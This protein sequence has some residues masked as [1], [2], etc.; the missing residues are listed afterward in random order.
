M[1]LRARLNLPNIGLVRRYLKIATVLIALIGGLSAYASTKDTHTASSVLA[2]VPPSETV[3]GTP[4][5]PIK[6]IDQNTAQLALLAANLADDPTVQRAVADVGATME[7]ASALDPSATGSTPGAQVRVVVN[8]PTK[9][10]A[11]DGLS[12]A[13]TRMEQAFGD[14][15]AQAGVSA[16]AKQAHLVPMVQETPTVSNPG[17]IRNAL[18]TF[19]TILLGGI[20]V[21]LLVG[22]PRPAP[23]AGS[24]DDQLGSV[25]PPHA[26]HSHAAQHH[27]SPYVARTRPTRGGRGGLTTARGPVSDFPIIAPDRDAIV[28]DQSNPPAELGL[29]GGTTQLEAA[30]DQAAAADKSTNHRTAAFDAAS[31]VPTPDEVDDH[32]AWQQPAPHEPGDTTATT[33]PTDDTASS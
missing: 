11:L 32:A 28:V 22:P 31:G 29:T 15:Q 20:I 25:G 27:Q 5:N 9:A 19:A 13:E 17:R 7:S 10:K 6:S 26:T 30:F 23:G 3:K 33:P 4:I 18:T 1:D 24:H 8:A 16:L 2:V 14:F 12:V 21:L